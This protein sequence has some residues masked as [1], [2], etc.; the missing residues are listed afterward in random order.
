MRLN[1]TMKPPKQCKNTFEVDNKNTW[2]SSSMICKIIKCNC[3]IW[4]KSKLLGVLMIHENF[5][6]STL[7]KRGFTQFSKIQFTLF[8]HISIYILAFH[9][10]AAL[11]WSD[12]NSRKHYFVQNILSKRSVRDRTKKSQWFWMETYPTLWSDS[13]SSW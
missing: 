9:T 5:C 12:L 10:R 7:Q 6:E 2:S 13:G 4:Q 11:M 3:T 1:S 8:N